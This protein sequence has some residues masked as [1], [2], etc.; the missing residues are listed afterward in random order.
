MHIDALQGTVRAR[1]GQTFGANDVAK[2]QE[3]ISSLGP[4]SRLDLDFDAVREC[5]AATLASLAAVLESMAG[6]QV[7]VRRLSVPH[8][9]F[10][11]ANDGNGA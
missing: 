2:L 11:K 7:T 3:A 5:D 9:R 8:W 4:V 10:L 6:V 1:A